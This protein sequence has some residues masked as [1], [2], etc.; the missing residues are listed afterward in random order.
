ML[1]GELIAFGMVGLFFGLFLLA[2]IWAW[3]SRQF[4][5]IEEVKY[6]VLEDED[7]PFDNYHQKLIR[8]G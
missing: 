7:E 3:R 1:A 5:Y 2:F 6:M 8:T 4:Q